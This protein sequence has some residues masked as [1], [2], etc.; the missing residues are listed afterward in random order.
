MLSLVRA[1]IGGILFWMQ[2]GRPKNS[3]AHA[4][5]SPKTPWLRREMWIGPV[6]GFVGSLIATI[7][8]RLLNFPYRVEVAL[9]SYLF[10]TTA[11]AGYVNGGWRAHAWRVGVVLI[12][13]PLVGVMFVHF[14]M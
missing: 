14:A 10:I 3:G 9:A 7:V 8:W 2:T 4:S 13:V 5:M 6:S 12:L 1:E 11:V